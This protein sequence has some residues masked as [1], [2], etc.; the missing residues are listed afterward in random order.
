MTN[1]I[2]PAALKA[3]IGEDEELAILDLREEGEFAD[4][5]LLFATNL[6]L[7]RL[8]L[9]IYRR[10]PRR[11]VP[12]VLCDADGG[13]TATRGAKRLRELGYS[14]V[15]ILDGGM[16]GWSAAGFE[17]FSG[18]HVP[19]K[20]FGEF[21]EH[22]HDTPRLTA[23]DLNARVAEGE[24]LV[25][26]DSRPWDEYH[27]MNIPGGINCPGA[28]L[29]YR[30]RDLAP[31]PET[32]VV[33][34]CAGRTRSIIGAQSLINAG[35]PNRVFALENGTMGWHLAGLALERGAE[36]RFGELSDE[37]RAAAI[38]RTE[39]VAARFEV[40]T[41]DMDELAMWQGEAGR[42]SL[43][44]VDVRDPAE[45]EAG[46]LDGSFNAPGGQL[47][48]ESNA[49]VGAMGA[50]IALIDGDGVRATM[51]ASWLIQLGW[52]DVAV[53]RGAL[54]GGSLAS[55][56]YRPDLPENN[57]PGPDAINPA[58]LAVLLRDGSATVIDVGD[59]PEYKCGHISGAWFALRA[60]LAQVL[61]SL[62][63]AGELIFTSGQG[64][65]ARYAARD[66]ER[67]TGRPVRVLAGGNEAWRAAGFE[68]EEGDGRMASEPKDAWLK[69]YDRADSQDEWMRQY[70]SWETALVEAV[71][72]DGGARFQHFPKTA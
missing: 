4:D 47:V 65:L 16:A 53:V 40:R 17:T 21:V 10:L 56:S 29:V 63:I 57:A 20:A 25:I 71:E 8:E 36:R 69:P 18:M 22:W 54:D 60:E 11:S 14:H 24:N 52:R 64:R 51:T 39:G 46:H 62:P 42:R 1:K 66:A 27:R 23:E 45:Y 50:R 6:S 3:R 26:L 32:T 48:Q 41:I 58:T 44:L 9:D 28:E 5:H 55:G 37:A 7:S 13:E 34:N 67:I 59:S 70:L 19:S 35:I 33:V 43:Y 38:A 61:D 12:I 72:R 30:V 15:E 49:Y 31:D 68:L 2:S